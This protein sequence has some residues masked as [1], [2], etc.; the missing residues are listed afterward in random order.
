MT[1]GSATINITHDPTSLQPSTKPLPITTH[2]TAPI[3]YPHDSTQPSTLTLKKSTFYG[4][5]LIRRKLAA[6]YFSSK[7][8]ENSDT[9]MVFHCFREVAS[10][11]LIYQSCILYWFS[12][13]ASLSCYRVKEKPGLDQRNHR[14]NYR[15]VRYTYTTGSPI[16]MSE[17]WIISTGIPIVVYVNPF[18]FTDNILEPQVLP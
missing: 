13:L 1:C 8:K 14:M 16:Y 6:L 3:H 15:S 9:E 2:T 18:F 4:R 5:F 7:I 17:F 11:L 10:F 12:F